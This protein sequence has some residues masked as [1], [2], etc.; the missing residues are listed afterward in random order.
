EGICALE[1]GESE[2]S[3]VAG[4]DAVLDVHDQHRVGGARSGTV[5]LDAGLVAGDGGVGDEDGVDGGELAAGAEGDGGAADGGGDQGSGDEGCGRAPPVRP[6]E[7]A[8]AREGGCVQLRA[9]ARLDLDGG[10][11]QHRQE[12]GRVEVQVIE[13]HGA[14]RAHRGDVEARPAG[15]K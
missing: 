3:L 6:Q 9:R 14:A 4:N 5:V 8:P 10:D 7:E 11:V 2:V 15:E 12:L 1:V 13:G